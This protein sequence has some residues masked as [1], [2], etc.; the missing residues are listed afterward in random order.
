MKRIRSPRNPLVKTIRRLK[1]T[2][3]R[4]P[5]VLIEGR[6]LV[7]EAADSGL[8]LETVLVSSTFTGDVNL[9]APTAVLPEALFKELSTLTTPEGILAV[10]RRPKPAALPAGGT[11]AV[12]AG[13]QDPG[14]LGAIARV[15]EAAGASALVVLEGSADPFGPKTVRASAGS[16][17][18]LPIVEDVGPG[19]LD[20]FRLVALV[21]R[22]GRDFRRVSWEPPVAILLGAEGTGLDEPLLARTELLVSIPMAGRVE[23]LNV[24]TA[25]ALVLFEATRR[26]L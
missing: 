10:A 23:S 9:D 15:A 5:L 19:A 4:E 6:K 16:V 13:I 17:L 25:A 24:A 18:R 21:P 20:R 8:D 11:V 14:N 22:G 26:E 3:S 1:R 7:A 12:A 2:G